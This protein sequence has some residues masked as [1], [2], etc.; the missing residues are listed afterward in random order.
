VIFAYIANIIAKLSFFYFALFP[1]GGIVP[2]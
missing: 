2:K 1:Y